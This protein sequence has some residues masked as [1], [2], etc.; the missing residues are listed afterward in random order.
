MIG[1][2]INKQIYFWENWQTRYNKE[3]VLGS[4]VHVETDRY[5]NLEP[6]ADYGLLDRPGK[7]WAN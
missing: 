3:F 1:R 7:V 6:L 2:I 4:I 5:I